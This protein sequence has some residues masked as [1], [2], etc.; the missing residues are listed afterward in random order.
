MGIAETL[1]PE[2]DQEMATTRRML[3]RTPEAQA[4]WKPHPKS[5]TLGELAMHLATLPLWGVTT[6]TQ[7]ELDMNPPGGPPSCCRRFSPPQP[8]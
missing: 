5:M 4:G 3:E 7:T 6:L 8:C 1:L 2:F